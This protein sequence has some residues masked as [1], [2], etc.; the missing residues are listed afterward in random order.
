MSGMRVAEFREIRAWMYRNARPIDLMRWKHRYEGGGGAAIVALLRSY[1]NEDGGFGHGLEADNWNPNSSPYTTG[2]A[3]ELLFESGEPLA[4]LAVA[5]RD[6]AL[7]RRA[8]GIAD[9]MAEKLDAARTMDCHELQCYVKFWEALRRLGLDG[10]YPANAIDKLK[11]FVDAT[12][13]RD[14]AKWPVYSMRP[15]MYIDGP[16]SPY[17]PGN[18]KSVEQEIDYILAS[19]KPGGVWEISWRWAGYDAEYAVAA[20]WWRGWWAMRNL[21]ILQ[22]FGRLDRG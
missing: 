7:Y 6:G 9:A 17:Y 12:I 8:L 3:I 15:S 1:Q 10:R 5:P 2:T 13:E 4:G 11:G 19:R 18:E 22:S 14:P 16:D 21:Q 20:N